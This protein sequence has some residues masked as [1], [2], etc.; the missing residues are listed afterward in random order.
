MREKSS[1]AWV[2][3]HATEEQP[4]CGTPPV[5]CYTESISSMPPP[6]PPVKSNFVDDL[7]PRQPFMV[8]I[9]RGRERNT[10][11]PSFLVYVFHYLLCPLLDRLTEGRIVLIASKWSLLRL[12]RDE[13]SG[14][15]P[16]AI[17]VRQCSGERNW[18][19]RSPRRS[20][21]P[22]RLNLANRRVRVI[23]RVTS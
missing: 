11:C 21:L 3:V 20:R 4:F 18:Y 9:V 16:S 13:V 6:L 1:L 2:R 12:M 8:W 23:T 10:K 19:T 14:S 5:H 17:A 7:S 22:L 15:L